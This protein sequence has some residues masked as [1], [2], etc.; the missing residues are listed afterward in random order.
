MQTPKSR[1]KAAPTERKLS[2]VKIVGVAFQPRYQRGHTTTIRRGDTGIRRC[3]VELSP[4][5]RVGD[6]TELPAEFPLTLPRRVCYVP[7]LTLIPVSE[8]LA[9]ESESFMVLVVA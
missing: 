5:L 3:G 9:H 2:T 1:L 6:F 8:R 4:R 7:K